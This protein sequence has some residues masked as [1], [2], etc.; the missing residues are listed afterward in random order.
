MASTE[1]EQATRA[2]D[3]EGTA[4][5]VTPSEAETPAE[6][7][8]IN[9]NTGG[10]QRVQL[11]E[12]P[13]EWTQMGQCDAATAPANVIRYPSEVS[14]FTRED[15]EILIVGTAGQK[16]TRMGSKFYEEASPRL[17]RL[18]F[19]SHLI[20]TMEGLDGFQNL[21]LLELYD[22]MVE[23]LANL[24]DGEGGAPGVTLT[25]LDM[26]YNAIRDMQP[27][28]FCPNLTELCKW[29]T[30][31]DSLSTSEGVHCLTNFLDFCLNP[32][33]N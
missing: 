19:R 32:F 13:L 6:N 33:K 4:A 1:D 16:I 10:G 21:Q 18:V 28:E 9:S 31:M 30:T 15:T 23:E 24:S 8:E 29:W 17:E 3:L 2:E 22:N 7:G 26:S 25:T 12:F 11:G 20:R 27:V 5:E 14:D